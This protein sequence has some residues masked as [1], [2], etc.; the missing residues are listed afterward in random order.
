MKTTRSVLTLGRIACCILSCAAATVMSAGSGSSASDNLVLLQL[1]K[2][3]VSQEE[4]VLVTVRVENKSS[5]SLHLD[6]GGDGKDNIL[7]SVTGPDG[8][9]DQ[10][11]REA[12]RGRTTFFGNV[13]L[14]SGENYSE[15]I[16]LS[17]WFHFN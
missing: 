13:H 7:V 14:G 17:E 1:E 10:E 12:S 4:P 5:K 3:V 15:T 9:L 6:L 16:V 8:T 11:R 2:S